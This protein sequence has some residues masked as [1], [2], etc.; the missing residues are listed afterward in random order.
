M[1][2]KK[3]GNLKASL[4]ITFFKGTKPKKKWLERK[5]PLVRFGVKKKGW[6]FKHKRLQFEVET[7][8]KRAKR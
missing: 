7:A 2:K 1:N 8:F 6:S 3:K 5:Q 4:D